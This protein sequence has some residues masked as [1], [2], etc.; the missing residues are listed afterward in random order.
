[1]SLMKNDPARAASDTST[2]YRRRGVRT[3]R[4]G[5]L[6]LDA[7]DLQTATEEIIADAQAGHSRLVVTPNIH[8]LRLAH[9]DARFG[10]VLRGAEY[11]LA[12][13]WPLIAS[14]RL[15]RPPLPERVAGID[16]VDNILQQSSRMRVAILGGPP[17]AAGRLGEMLS[18]RHTVVYVDELTRDE[19]D[20]PERNQQRRTAIEA[21]APNLTLIGIGAPRQELLGDSLRSA[22]RGP[23]LCCGA[24]IEVLAELTPRAPAL[25]RSTGLEWAFRLLHEPRR[26]G[27][28]Y[29][30][31]GVLL[32]RTMMS[33]VFLRRWRNQNVV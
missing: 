9:G 28:R 24:T 6:A 27:P 31:A 14:S 32:T 13:G 12:D 8:H 1:M 21:A 3:F 20:R 18:L 19:W 15:L 2:P 11:R 4:F 29:L 7:V 22:V 17:G 30:A 5:P 23:I 10:E 25:L 26:L 33:E 16:L